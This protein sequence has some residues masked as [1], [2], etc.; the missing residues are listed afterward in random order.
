MF[1]IVEAPVIPEV[2]EGTAFPD[3]TANAATF[4]NV[5]LFVAEL[6][7]FDTATTSA[8]FGVVFATSAEIFTSAIIILHVGYCPIRLKSYPVT[9]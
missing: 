4:P 3:E 9:P 2:S 8:A 6:S 1:V 5:T 7:L